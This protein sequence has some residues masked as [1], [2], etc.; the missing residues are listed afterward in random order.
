[1]S[2]ANSATQGAG[3][4]ADVPARP[5]TR[6]PDR[7]TYRICGRCER[8][9]CPDC[10]VDTPVG[11]RC[12]ECARPARSARLIIEWWRWPLIAAVALAMALVFGGIASTIS[13]FGLLLAYLG[14]AMIGQA[15]LAASH[16][17][18]GAPL[19]LVTV[20]CAVVGALLSEPMRL[21]LIT[22]SGAS[23][24]P[25]MG[26][27]AWEAV[28]IGLTDVWNWLNAVVMAWAAWMRLT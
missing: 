23:N 16:R 18:P 6:H 12:R 3:A 9:F 8:P 11:G 28:K 21:A 13:L 14:G 7:E 26:I 22:W 17:R 27:I 25:P 20:V 15:A 1:M 5:C 4:K 10:L 2:C 19:A 24:A